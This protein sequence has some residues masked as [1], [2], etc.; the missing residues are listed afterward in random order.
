VEGYSKDPQA[1]AFAAF[2]PN[3]LPKLFMDLNLQVVRYEDVEAEPDWLK[4]DRVVR[5]FARKSN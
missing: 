4:L 3:E 5:I 1:P 2:G